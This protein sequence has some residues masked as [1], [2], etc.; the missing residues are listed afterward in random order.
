[1]LAVQLQE[2][3]D[4]GAYIMSLGISCLL[5]SELPLFSG[6]P[7]LT[8]MAPWYSS[9]NSAEKAPY[10]NTPTQSAELDLTQPV[11]MPF[12]KG[13]RQAAVR[14]LGGH[15]PTPGAGSRV[16]AWKCRGSQKDKRRAG[17]QPDARSRESNLHWEGEGTEGSEGLGSHDR[18]LS[19]PQTGVVPSPE[20]TPPQSPAP[21]G[22]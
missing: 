22:P 4:P 8:Q 15:I 6:G 20:H 18:P 16:I 13:R 3:L 12:S 5:S 11:P 17:G 10:P 14:A 1:M 21:D 2:E 7:S 9:S 19:C